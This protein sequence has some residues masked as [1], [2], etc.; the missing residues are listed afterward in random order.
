ME[1]FYKIADL[2]EAIL[3]A[4]L[5]YSKKPAERAYTPDEH[6]T[7]LPLSLPGDITIRI[8]CQKENYSLATIE[9]E[10][11]DHVGFL[12]AIAKRVAEE[13]GVHLGR[14]MRNT[15]FFSRQP[16]PTHYFFL[17]EKSPY[18]VVKAYHQINSANTLYLKGK[19]NHDR[20]IAGFLRERPTNT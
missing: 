18:N 7:T 2:E 6:Y 15:S 12:D 9:T 4:G 16:Q 19:K 13:K 1:E 10:E 8:S 14:G 5:S 20:F 17:T 11:Y 3:K